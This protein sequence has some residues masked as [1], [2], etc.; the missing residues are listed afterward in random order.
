MECVLAIQISQFQTVSG[1]E[2]HENILIAAAGVVIAAAAAVV[3]EEEQRED[4]RKGL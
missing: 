2:N 1:M 3:E 4:K